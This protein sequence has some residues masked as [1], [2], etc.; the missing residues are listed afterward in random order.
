MEI[1]LKESRVNT[2]IFCRSDRLRL[3]RLTA[4]V[5]FSLSLGACSGDTWKEEVL[6][7]DGQKII[8]ERSQTY[9][10]RSEIGQPTPVGEHTI[11]FKLPSSGKQLSWTSEY[12]EEIGRTD[13]N[14]VAIH[15]KNNAAYVIA[16]PNLCLSYNKWGRPNPPYVVFKHDG[17]RWIR[18]PIELLPAEF[19]SVNTVQYLSSGDRKHLIEAGKVS[20]TEVAA[21][22]EVVRQPELKTILREKINYDPECIS[23]SSNGKGRWRATAW[24]E[25]K[26]DIDS[27]RS[28][29]LN[30]GYDEKHCPCNSIF[31]R[32]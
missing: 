20:A 24:F 22:N 2:R 4:A 6:L 8:V 21:L 15:V 28:A 10:G 5:A 27:C 30:D 14:L 16:A 19:K 1:N 3:G 32:K 29:C 12:G 7:H 25:T 26:P 23:M 18:E 13:F 31:Q 9:K 17:E 11:R